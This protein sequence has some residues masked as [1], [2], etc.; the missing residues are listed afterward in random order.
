LNID[1]IIYKVKKRD[2]VA[3]RELFKILS[4]SL[5]VVCTRY[6][7]DSSQ[8]KDF[9][10]E[11][12]IKIFSKIHLFDS[13]HTGSFEGWTYR[14]SVNTILSLLRKKKKMIV[15]QYQSELPDKSESLSLDLTPFSDEQLLNCI[16]QLPEK[17]RTV[18]N[19]KIFENYSHEE[20]AKQLNI[21]VGSSRSQFSRA[22]KILKSMLEKI[23]TKSYVNG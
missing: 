21:A 10:Q 11:C 17:Y 8:A 9:L 2:P 14:I 5:I 18:I 15:L 20:I 3:E 1:E 4:P 19:L 22:K 7:S 12:F 16:Q 23:N 13:N 6:A